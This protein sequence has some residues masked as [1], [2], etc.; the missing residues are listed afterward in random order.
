MHGMALTG[1]HKWPL[2]AEPFMK[3]T[4][5]SLLLASAF[6]TVVRAE[7]FKLPEKGP[8]V[9]FSFPEKWEASKYD[10]GVEATSED[11]EVYIAIEN[12]KTKDVEKSIEASIKY[13]KGKGVVP[14]EDSIQQKEGE[15]NGMEA[16]QIV[17]TGK[18]KDGPCNISLAIIAATDDKGVLLMYWASPEGE[19]KNQPDLNKILASL[20]PT[21][22]AAKADKEDDE[23]KAEDKI[24]KEEKSDKPEKSKKADKEEEEDEEK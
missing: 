8:V 1:H 3:K 24:E 22:A 4:L 12:V 15:V 18:D 21:K 23:D 16:V 14:K 5:T 10:E 7:S 13:L 6:L 17:W 9:S 2:M 20:K 11:G 19:K